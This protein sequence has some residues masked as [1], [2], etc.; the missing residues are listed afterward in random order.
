[1]N[2]TAR[3]RQRASVYRALARLF[4]PPEADGLIELRGF[5]LPAQEAA[6]ESGFIRAW[7]VGILPSGEKIL[8]S[9]PNQR[10]SD[11]FAGFIWRG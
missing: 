11:S 3:H 8:A 2:A 6:E 4:G 7:D 10:S 1:M 5:D 9:V